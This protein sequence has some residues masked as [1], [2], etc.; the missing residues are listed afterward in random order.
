MEMETLAELYVDE[1]DTD[2]TW[3]K[4]AETINVAA[5]HTDE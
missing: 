4:L 2:K 5:E 3:T 1:G